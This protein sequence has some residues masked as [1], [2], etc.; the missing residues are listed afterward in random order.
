MLQVI[1]CKEDPDATS[2][3]KVF[4]HNVYRHHGLPYVIIC[5]WEPVFMSKFW[6]KI[7]KLLKTRIS[8]SSAYYPETEGQTEIINRKVEEVIKAY[9]DY[10]TRNSDE[11]VI[12][13]EVAYNSSIHA[14]TWYTPF[15]LNDAQ[16]P[17]IIRLETLDSKTAAA[18]SFFEN[19]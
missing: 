1:P 6:T 10:D 17:R 13:L 8:P 9:V 3:E 14:T 18:Y 12:H 11:Y 15:F 4:F 5:D 16:H 19:L 2:A 7:F